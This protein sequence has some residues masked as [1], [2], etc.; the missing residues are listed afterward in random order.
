VVPVL[1]RVRYT[2][3]R[4]VTVS[5]T[6]LRETSAKRGKPGPIAGVRESELCSRGCDHIYQ[7]LT[8]LYLPLGLYRG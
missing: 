2:L 6:P 4:V 8:D 7:L 5:S 3:R 1:P